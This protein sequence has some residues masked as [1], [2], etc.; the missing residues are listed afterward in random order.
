[1]SLSKVRDV[2]LSVSTSVN[3]LYYYTKRNI[4]ERVLRQHPAV[5]LGGLFY[6]P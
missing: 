4:L 6:V 3:C 1:M 5:S 2:V